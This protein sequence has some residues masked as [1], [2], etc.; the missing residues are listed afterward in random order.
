M[1]LYYVPILYADSVKYLGF[2]FT[3]DLK[4]VIDMLRQLR[5]IYARSNT[6]LRQFAKCGAS[7][8]LELFKRFCS[9]YYCPILWLGMTKQSSR[10]LRI[11]YNNAHRKILNLHMRCSATQMFV[12]NG[13]MNFEALIRN[14]PTFLLTV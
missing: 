12:D 8:N 9:C 10:K 5:T 3:P 1:V 11:A 14:I 4:D 6:I 2:M 13:L 7:V